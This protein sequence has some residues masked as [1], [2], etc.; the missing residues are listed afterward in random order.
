MAILPAT[1]HHSVGV[2]TGWPYSSILWLDAIASLIFNFYLSV[3]GHTTISADLC[4]RYSGKLLGYQ[5]TKQQSL[6]L[7]CKENK[8]KRVKQS[9]QATF[10]NTDCINILIWHLSLQQRYSHTTAQS[11]A[12]DA[13]G[14]LRYI[15]YD[16]VKTRVLNDNLWESHTE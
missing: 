14:R 7:S 15:W 16:Q 3:A 2:R 9:S 1:L 10:D 8:Y 11:E 5:A 4:L 6:P 13:L 12:E